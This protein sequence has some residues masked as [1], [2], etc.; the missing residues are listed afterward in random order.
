MRLRCIT[1]NA[2]HILLLFDCDIMN[3]IYLKHEIWKRNNVEEKCNG[4]LIAL[5][6]DHD[7][8]ILW[9]TIDTLPVNLLVDASANGN[10]WLS[11]FTYAWSMLFQIATRKETTLLSYRKLSSLAKQ[12][13]S[14]NEHSTYIYWKCPVSITAYNI[15][16]ILFPRVCVYISVRVLV[17]L[18]VNHH[19]VLWQTVGDPLD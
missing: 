6:S 13:V 8:H 15:D 3:I 1:R 2:V 7:W 17:M 9:K 10:E 19:N 16:L 12:K 5:P 4:L 11:K 14:S 18:P